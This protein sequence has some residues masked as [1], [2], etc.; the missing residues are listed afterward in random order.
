[1]AG[2]CL[3]IVLMQG[4]TNTPTRPTQTFDSPKVFCPAPISRLSPSGQPA[5]IS[6][7][8]PTVTGGTP[9][10]TASCSPVSGTTFP[11]GVTNVTCT[12]TD[13]VQR[14]NSCTFTVT[15]TAPPRLSAT[16]F[17]AFGDSITWGEDGR[18]FATSLSVPTIRPR[19]QFPAPNT[20]PGALQGLLAARYTA[21]TP[22]VQNAGSPGEMVT[23][24]RTFPRFVGLTSS[25]A[26]DVVLLMEGANDLSRHDIPGVINGLARMVD[27]AKSRQ[28]RVFLATI[29]PENPLGFNP[30]RGVEA[31]QVPPLND[32]IRV[33][34]ISKN[35]PL[36]D[37]YQ[38]F[39]GDLSLLGNDG[40]H[41]TAAGYHVIADAFFASIRQTLE[42]APA[43]SSNPQR[44]MRIVVP[45]RSR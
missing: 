32:Q 5:A 4:C 26:Y 43:T 36:V 15:I 17:L 42:L 38:A 30:D 11:I 45:P 37:V 27:D 10:T 25:G 16:R 13:Q 18:D 23:D 29:P 40:L 24:S 33:L 7:G 44:T 21:Q 1:V 20:Y 6:Y 28:M 39:G 3:G 35:V 9:P 34:A 8:A 19:V 2:V 41:P 31:A 14:T 22:Q 12:A